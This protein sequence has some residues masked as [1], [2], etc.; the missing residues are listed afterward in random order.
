M[1]LVVI[2]DVHGNLY[3]LK[4]IFNYIEKMD[5]DGV[6][7]CGDYITD[8]PLSHEVLHFMR[9]V[10]RKYKYWLVSGNREDY[11]I[12]Y[13]NNKSIYWDKNKNNANLLLT[14]ESLTAEDLEYIRGM[15]SEEFILIPNA[16]SIYLSHKFKQVTDAKYAI[17]GH[18]HKQY[19]FKKNNV[20]Y[21]SPG[22]AGL[23]TSQKASSEFMMM[24]LK[25]NVWDVRMYQIDYDISLPINAIKTSKLESVAVKWGNALIRSIE[26]GEDYTQV[27]ID[28]VRKLANQKGISSDLQ[29]IPFEIWHTA[30]KQIDI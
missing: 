21:L 15:P 19:N 18:Y 5:I 7:W 25:D 2:S 6:I 8:V 13:H 30:R 23:P 28:A 14:Y 26:T 17:F 11:I 4:S 3:A 1:K 27:Y 12:E 10:N 22:S 29:D 16:P 9:E 24:S 20:I